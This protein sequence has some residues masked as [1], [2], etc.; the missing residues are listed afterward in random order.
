LLHDNES[1]L[2]KTETF[3]RLITPSVVYGRE[4]WKSTLFLALALYLRYN[5]RMEAIALFAAF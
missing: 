2:H 1:H 5:I 4:F 3:F